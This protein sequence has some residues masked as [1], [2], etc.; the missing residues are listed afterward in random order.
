MKT[1]T[2][3]VCKRTVE[4]HQPTGIRDEMRKL[5]AARW[6]YLTR[7]GLV[8]RVYCTR[9]IGMDGGER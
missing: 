7:D 9:C 4:L 1:Y 3:H 6:S 8:K 5:N 2:C